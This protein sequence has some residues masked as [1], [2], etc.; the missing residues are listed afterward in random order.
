[1]IDIEKPWL[2]F[3]VMFSVA[4]VCVQ[5]WGQCAMSDWSEVV[6]RVAQN[7]PERDFVIAFRM[8]LLAMLLV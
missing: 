4:C 3:T 1:M 6:R 8:Q 5:D 2:G 7:D